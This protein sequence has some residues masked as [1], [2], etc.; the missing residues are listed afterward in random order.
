MKKLS[1]IRYGQRHKQTGKSDLV[2][3]IK[4]A[5]YIK[6]RWHLQFNRE[7]YIGFDNEDKIQR[8]C[9]YVTERDSRKF[10]WRNP[11]LSLLHKKFG[12]IIIEV[13]GA[14]H[15]RY[16]ER[17]ERRNSLYERNQVKLVVLNVG[18]IKASG[19]SLEEALDGHFRRIGIGQL[20]E[21]DNT[22]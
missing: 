11:D 20:D 19:K 2:Q 22:G 18:E 8:I 4:L 9:E 16:V 15:D 1:G 13:D 14:V 3:L 7:W 21:Q 5:N 12:L 10:R 6:D 17:T